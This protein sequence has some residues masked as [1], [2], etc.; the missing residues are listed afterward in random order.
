MNLDLSAKQNNNLNYDHL[1]EPVTEYLF[2]YFCIASF[3][4]LDFSFF[5]QSMYKILT[6]IASLIILSS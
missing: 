2:F 1:L 4:D 3:L 5:S 6:F